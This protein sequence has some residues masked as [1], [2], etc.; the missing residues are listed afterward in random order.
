MFKRQANKYGDTP[1]P[2]TPYQKAAE[3][4][5]QRIGSA[6]AQARNWRLMAFFCLGFVMM[7]SLALI[8][9]SLSSRIT[10]YVV[11]V[12]DSGSVRAV[13]N[14]TES[15]SPSDAQIAYH[16]S[17][18]IKNMRS[19]AIDPVVVRENWLKAYDYV[20]DRGALVL[21]EYARDHDPFERIGE[22]S[23]AVE[24][25]S[26]V[27]AS[28]T[29]FQIKWREAVHENGSLVATETYTAILSLILQQPK[30]ID[31]LRKNPLGIYVHGFNWSKDLKP[32]DNS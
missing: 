16:L 4:W 30:T 19:I 8:W 24:V 13:G 20:T 9:Q 10:P 18:F 23:I 3:I 12:A 29:S 25:T 1:K 22:R 21:N 17:S 14:A 32:G 28:D 31:Q 15:Y 27:R 6:R 7:M 26:V 11:E 5:D 2:T